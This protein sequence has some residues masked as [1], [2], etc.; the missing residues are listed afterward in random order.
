ML[1]MNGSVDVW[2]MEQL[3]KSLL[4]TFWW[5]GESLSERKKIALYGCGAPMEVE[6]LEKVAGMEWNGVE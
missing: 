4:R 6:R 3:T 1:C 2:W 5:G